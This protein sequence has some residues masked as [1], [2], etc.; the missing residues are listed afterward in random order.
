MAQRLADRLQWDALGEHQT[1]GAVPKVVESDRLKAETGRRLVEDAGDRIGSHRVA[2][3]VREHEIG[4]ILP[5]S[6]GCEPL[7]SLRCLLAS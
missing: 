5:R 3:G 7:D 6:S 1:R 4:L 2:Q